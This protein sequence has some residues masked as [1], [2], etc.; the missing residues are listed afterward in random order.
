MGFVSYPHLRPLINGQIFEITIV[1]EIFRAIK[2]SLISTQATICISLSFFIK[3]NTYPTVHRTPSCAV[4]I[5]G[6]VW[7]P[8][9]SC[10][11]KL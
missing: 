11:R 5:A 1:L 8:S 6:P 4:T 7:F 2:H 10:S 9:T 3:V